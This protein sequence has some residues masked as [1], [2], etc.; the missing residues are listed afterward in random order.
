MSCASPRDGVR[1]AQAGAA[2]DLG[3]AA[4]SEHLLERA[5]R[6]R[7]ILARAHPRA[8]L[9][10]EAGAL[11]LLEQRPQAAEPAAT[12]TGAPPSTCPRMSPSPP[13][14]LL[15]RPETGGRLAAAVRSISGHD[16]ES[17]PSGCWLDLGRRSPPG[18]RWR[19]TF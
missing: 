2:R 7:Q 6:E 5:R 19:R 3:E 16:R 10:A 9:I 18:S 15:A 12:T 8:G 13:P 14:P 11:E 1:F 17:A 4:R